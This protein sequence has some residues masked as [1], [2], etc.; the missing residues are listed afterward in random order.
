[1][2]IIARENQSQNMVVDVRERNP[3]RSKL[4]RR[5]RVEMKKKRRA[6]ARDLEPRNELERPRFEFSF[7]PIA[8][9]VNRNTDSPKLIRN[10]KCTTVTLPSHPRT[11][12][13]IELSLSI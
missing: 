12:T 3:Q 9:Q 8:S 13:F 5:V 1:M 4:Y 2:R 11:D 6:M 7:E 10:V